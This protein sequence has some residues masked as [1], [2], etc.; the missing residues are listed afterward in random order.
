M[1]VLGDRRYSNYFDQPTETCRAPNCRSVLIGQEAKPD[2]EG[3]QCG[4]GGTHEE[5]RFKSKKQKEH[6]AKQ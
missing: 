1:C 2:L 4:V 3:L 5:D 6:L